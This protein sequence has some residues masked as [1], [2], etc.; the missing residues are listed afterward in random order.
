MSLDY[1]LKNSQIRK[2]IKRKHYYLIMRDKL[3]CYNFKYVDSI[4]LYINLFLIE[5]F[6]RVKIK[7]KVYI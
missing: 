4:V 5:Y 6:K 2:E 1:Y 3:I 7:K